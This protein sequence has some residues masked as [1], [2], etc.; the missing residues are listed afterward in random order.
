MQD[1][2]TIADRLPTIPNRCIS[3]HVDVDGATF[4]QRVEELLPEVPDWQFRNWGD[5]TSLGKRLV[6]TYVGS[7]PAGQRATDLIC[8]LFGKEQTNEILLDVRA[9]SWLNDQLDY[10]LYVAA[11]SLFKSVLSA[12]NRKYGT[13]R[14]LRIPKQQSLEPSLPP[15]AQQYF[16][17]FLEVADRRAL[18]TSAWEELYAFISYVHSHNVR[19]SD[20][21]FYRLLEL[22]GFSS[23]YA[24]DLAEFYIHARNLLHL[25]RSWPGWNAMPP[26]SCWYGWLKTKE[27]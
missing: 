12:Y 18:S 24:H 8:Q 27:Q 4:L 9:A 6:L 14:R 20:S 7:A 23:E 3:I 1:K 5:S 16:N 26:H 19:L 25:R 21:D 11:A 13:R 10:D 2:P 17:W 22:N 15:G